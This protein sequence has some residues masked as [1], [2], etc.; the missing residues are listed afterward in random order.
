[1]QDIG[2]RALIVGA[3]IACVAGKAPI[4]V[5]D[6]A[7]PFDAFT[8]DW[9]KV[10][11]KDLKGQVV[12]LNFWASWCAPCR[13]EL[14]TL[15]AY[16]RKHANDGLRIF[17]VRADDNAPNGSFNAMSKMLSFPLVWHLDAGAGYAPIGGELPSN[18]V[19]DAQG[20]IRYAQ[21]GAFD[22]ASLEQVVTPLL[23]KR[24]A[25]SAA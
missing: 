18:Y 8:F 12:L 7:P 5:G 25:G 2:R 20:V 19:I 9:K 10:H 21:A 16:Y 24:A 3:A 17:A 11:F 4:K 22:E 23:E 14:P 1:M 15:D 6:P 13:V